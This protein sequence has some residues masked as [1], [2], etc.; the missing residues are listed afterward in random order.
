MHNAHVATTA[1]IALSVSA[2][3]TTILLLHSTAAHHVAHKSYLIAADNQLVLLGVLAEPLSSSSLCE[4]LDNMTLLVV[5][6][7]S[8]ADCASKSW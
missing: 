6:A 1:A 7:R 4:V 8:N 5:S 2:C 3:T